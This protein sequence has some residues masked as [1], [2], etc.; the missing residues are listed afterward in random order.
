MIIP[1]RNIVNLPIEECWDT[2]TGVFTIRFDDGDYEVNEK[3]TLYSRYAW[4]FHRAYPGAPIKMSHH[5]K[6]MLN[7]RRV[8]PSTHLSLIKTSVVGRVR[9]P[10]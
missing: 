9:L 6:K 10:L 2:L 5:L 4:E 1:A 3:T 8:S 7:G